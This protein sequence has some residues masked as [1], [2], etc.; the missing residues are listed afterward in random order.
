M[1][2]SIST[3]ANSRFGLALFGTPFKRPGIGHFVQTQWGSGKFGTGWIRKDHRMNT[4]IITGATSGIGLAAARALLK[5]SFR[6][7]GIGH[8]QINCTNAKAE[9]LKEFPA[10]DLT[11]YWGDLMQQREVK[12]IAECLAVHLK[13]H[14]EG[15]LHALINNAGCTR[16]WYT[17]TEEGYEQQFA[18]NHLAGFMLTHYMMPYL[19]N[20]GRVIMTG[21][22]S[23]KH[24]KIHWQD[25]MFQKRYHPLLA[26]KQSKL[27]NMLFAQSLNT[28]YAPFGIKAY[29]VDPGLVA[30]D[31]GFKQT[32]GLVSL[33]WSIRKKQGV[34]PEVPAKTYAFL[35]SAQPPE[36]HLY[37][38]LCKKAP[39]SKQVTAANADRLFALCEKLCN[40]TFGTEKSI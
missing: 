37:Y 28:L 31:I 16:S 34:A 30:T 20:G 32:G 23:H 29:V 39:Y 2:K 40:I 17:T 22:G 3:A 21:S 12:R 24:M 18:V 1:M 4:V 14:C 13:E 36:D 9:L 38:Y 6:V 25:L 35:C 8:S 11:Y 7:I 27:C 33:V 5:Q 10:A 15:R 19:K 26:Y